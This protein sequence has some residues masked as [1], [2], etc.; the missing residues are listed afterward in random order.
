MPHNSY[1][2]ADEISGHTRVL[3][4]EQD[5]YEDLHIRDETLS[6]GSNAMVSKWTPTSEQLAILNGGGSIYLGIIGERHP[7]IAMA[8]ALVDAND[9]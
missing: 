2:K 1:M 3:A 7:P 5:E 4:T 6:D 9:G 8:V